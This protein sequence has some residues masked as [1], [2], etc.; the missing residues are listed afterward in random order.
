M[1]FEIHALMQYTHDQ[2]TCCVGDV[3]Y[4]M[5]LVFISS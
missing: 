4:D 2:N 3:K 1:P 5:G